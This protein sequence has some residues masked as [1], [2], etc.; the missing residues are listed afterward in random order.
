M[1]KALTIVSYFSAFLTAGAILYFPSIAYPSCPLSASP[2][3]WLP[4]SV[5]ITPALLWAVTATLGRVQGTF[6]YFTWALAVL[7]GQAVVAMAGVLAVGGV[8]LWLN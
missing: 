5:V 1:R 6:T 3:T 7:V 2:P 4:L 8:L